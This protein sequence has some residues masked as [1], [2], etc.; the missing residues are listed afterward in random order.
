M[1]LL[2]NICED[3]LSICFEQKNINWKIDFSASAED[4]KLFVDTQKV[5]RYLVCFPSLLMSHSFPKSLKVV[6][7]QTIEY[8][9]TATDIW[10]S[11]QDS[12][13]ELLYFSMLQCNTSLEDARKCQG[14]ALKYEA[15]VHLKTNDTTK[16]LAVIMSGVCDFKNCILCL[17]R[18][19]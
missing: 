13:D 12:E 2:S 8:Q 18:K 9:L 1:E 10:A 3:D 6:M 17:M 15:S 7:S 14:K 11:V 5:L 19:S 16:I 4:T